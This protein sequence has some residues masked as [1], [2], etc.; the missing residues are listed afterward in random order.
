VTVPGDEVRDRFGVIADVLIPGAGALDVGGAVLDTV[1]GSR[2]DLTDALWRALGAFDATDAI[3]WID[4]LSA[5]DGPAHDALVTCIVAA[6]YLHPTV[7]ARLGYPGQ[8][9]VAVAVD[10][11]PDYVDEGH[12]ER[13]LARGPIYRPTPPR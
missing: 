10:T 5:S 8:T 13:V 12:L 4:R 11:Y 9:G 3:A 7:Q 6:Y 1:L 2:P